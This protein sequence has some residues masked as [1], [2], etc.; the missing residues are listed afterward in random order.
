[1]GS[2][3]SSHVDVVRSWDFILTLMISHC[4]G[5]QLQFYRDY[6]GCWWKTAG[7]YEGKQNPVR[8]LVVIQARYDCGLGR[9]RAQELEGSRLIPA[10]EE[11]TMCGGWD[12][13]VGGQWGAKGG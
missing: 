4:R 10:V 7:R 3:L 12:V 6:C 13:G 9:T 5:I 11:L 2:Y 1:M 8:G